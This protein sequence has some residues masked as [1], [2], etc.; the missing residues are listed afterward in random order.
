FVGVEAARMPA[1]ELR[2]IEKFVNITGKVI[3]QDGNPVM[4]AT[5]LVK[6][7][8]SGVQTDKDGMFR[9]NLPEGNT[10]LVVSFVGYKVQEVN[11][12]GMTNITITL[13][14]S[15][16]IDEVVVT[17]YGTQKRSEIVGSVVTI[18]GEELM[19]IPAPRSEERRVGKEG[20]AGAARW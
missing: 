10:R 20:G 11:V 3:D 2:K 14:S 6:G 1:R 17:G 19:D 18:T 16:A 8:K 12:A 15:D 5:V 7:T 9:I 13:E 4:G